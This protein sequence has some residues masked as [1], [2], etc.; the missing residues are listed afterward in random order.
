MGELAHG[1]HVTRHQPTDTARALV[2]GASGF[3]GQALCRALVSEG[4]EPFA[5][6]R[7][8]SD[9]VGGTP[10]VTADL[11]DPV[12]VRQCLDR[13]KPDV[14]FHLA[15][16]TGATPALDAVLPTFAANLTSTVILLTAA[17]EVGC[18]RVVLAGSLEEPPADD[19][20]GPSS[21]YAASKW[22]A[23]MYARMFW[24][25]YRTPVTVARIFMVYGPNQRDENKLIPYTIR[26]LVS[27][28]EIRLSSPSRDVDWVFVDDVARGLIAL[29]RAANVEGTSIDIG[30][31]VLVSVRQVIERIVD[32]VGAP[33]Q[34]RFGTLPDRPNEQVRRADVN[35]TEQMIGWRPSVGL[36][37]GLAVTVDFYRGLLATDSPPAPEAPHYAQPPSNN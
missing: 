28:A 25:L 13:V 21:P 24:Q 14:I 22:A 27:G 15:G 32:L 17:T 31:G 3:I 7:P 26:S 4:V 37:E 6:R 9:M 16:L 29:S 10:Y 33:G 19:R 18:R 34:T 8:D 36:E 5:L 35:R 30:T 1:E 20:T 23:S 11:A 2:T 12:Q